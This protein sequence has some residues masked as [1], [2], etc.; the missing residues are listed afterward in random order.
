MRRFP[1]MVL[2]FLALH[3]WVSNAPASELSGS[4]TL[5]SEYIY[6]GL[7]MSDGEPALQL[8]LDY[9]HDSGLFAGAWGSTIDLG[10][11]LSQRDY[12]LDFYAG[13]HH[14]FRAPLTATMTLLRYTYP[15]Q[16]GVQDYDYNELLLSATFLEHYAIEVGY[17][18]DLYGHNVT[19]R[20]WALQ[21]EWPI[22]NAWVVGAT[23]GRNDLSNLG[24]AP[25]Y[26]W[27]IGASARYSRLVVD[28][29]WFDNENPYAFAA[30]T[31]ADSQLVLSLSVPF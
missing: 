17:T 12:E 31:S 9:A 29:R 20:H 8:G 24:V 30:A 6:R 16:E 5:T 28:V 2:A 18:N 26:Y 27:D 13:Y 22:A 4:A 7:A 10:G 23:L 3:P 1:F 25:Y 21:F 11:P 19:S 14:E 15:G